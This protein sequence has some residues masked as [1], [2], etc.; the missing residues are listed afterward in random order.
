MNKLIKPQ[1][2]SYTGED[3]KVVAYSLG[4][5]IARYATICTVVAGI[6]TLLTFSPFLGGITVACALTYV[7]SS[8][9]CHGYI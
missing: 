3:S 9:A 1:K 8:A 5:E 6:G 7:V 2:R 4:C